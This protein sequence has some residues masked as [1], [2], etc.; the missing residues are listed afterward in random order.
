MNTTKSL[1]FY[2]ILILLGISFLL[3][4]CQEHYEYSYNDNP[5]PSSK[6]IKYEN[7]PFDEKGKAMEKMAIGISK[8]LN[9]VEFRNLIKK[10]A[11]EKI[12]G[13]YDVLYHAIKNVYVKPI[14][15]SKESK[16]KSEFEG[17]TLHNFLTG[18]FENEQELTEFENKLPLLT[19][20]VPE[21]PENSFSAET[22]DIANPEQ[23][24]DVALRLDNTTYTPVVSKDGGFY[25]IEPELVPSYPIVVLKDN[26]RMVSS[27]DPLFNQLDTRVISSESNIKLRFLDETFDPEANYNNGTET[28]PPFVGVTPTNI[29]QYL[30]N[31][32]DVW[33]NYPAGGWQRDN[34][35]YGLTPT[36]TTGAFTYGKYREFIT[37]FR[38]TGL[39]SD[40]YYKVSDSFNETKKD[41]QLRDWQNTPTSAWTD[42]AFEFKVNINPGARA[43]NIAILSKAIDARQ[44]ELFDISWTSKTVKIPYYFIAGIPIFKTLTFYK[45]AING[46][47]TVFT[48]IPIKKTELSTWDLGDFANRWRY[49]FEEV[50]AS[51]TITETNST[52]YKYNL[53]I[54][55]SISGGDKIKA[56]LKYGASIEK[57]EVVTYSTSRM[58]GSDDLMSIDVAFYDQIVYKQNGQYFLRTYSTGAVEFTVAPVQVEF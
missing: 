12:D 41:P 16:V 47:K 57:S 22:W 52:T 38:L 10:K 39:P 33:E 8:A 53:N 15:K 46:L 35:Y 36:K 18:F 32:Y 2:F 3:N 7:I 29:P 4:S 25:L 19:V 11:L 50:D 28:P 49:S 1:S 6:E 17:G 58:E 43:G 26:E 45:P 14:Y 30:K 5:T 13:D 20:F 51:T 42:G 24:P 44:D 31:A 27:N 54:E 21:L 37:S 40:A 48:A 34:I 23:I 55:Y 9:N 56:G